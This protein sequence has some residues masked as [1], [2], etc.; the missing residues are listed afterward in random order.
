MDENYSN[1]DEFFLFQ[2]FRTIWKCAGTSIYFCD[3]VL[4]PNILPNTVSWQNTIYK[5]GILINARHSDLSL[6]S[7]NTYNIKNLIIKIFHR[8]WSRKMRSQIAV[9]LLLLPKTVFRVECLLQLNKTFHRNGNQICLCKDGSELCK[10]SNI[11]EERI[12]PVSW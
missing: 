3:L 5:K 2:T 8:V 4:V 9:T 10:H 7:W 1:W 6:S 12:H 11:I